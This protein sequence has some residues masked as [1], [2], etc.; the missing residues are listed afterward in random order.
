MKVFLAQLLSALMAKKTAEVRSRAVMGGGRGRPALPQNVDASLRL[1]TQALFVAIGL[2][3]FA[4]L[5]L[6]DFGLSTLF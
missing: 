6:A 2:H 4:T 1:V 5:V 3:A